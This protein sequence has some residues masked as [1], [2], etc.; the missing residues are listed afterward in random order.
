MQTF[1]QFYNILENSLSI[2]NFHKEFDG[3]YGPVKYILTLPAKRIRPILFLL[4]HQLYNDDYEQVL[5]IAIGIEWFHNFTLMH[6]DIMD[7]APLRRGF[8]TVHHKYGL[9]NA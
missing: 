7:S 6:D 9:N 1:S 2:D 4:S 8:S 5:P 3:L